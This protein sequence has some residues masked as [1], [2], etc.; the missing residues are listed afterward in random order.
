MVKGHFAILPSL[1]ISIAISVICNLLDL[2]RALILGA[3]NLVSKARVFSPH[4]LI[5][6]N[7]DIASCLIFDRCC[8]DHVE[9]K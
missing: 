2:P 1:R 4:I 5:L 9:I 3:V 6:G 7:D 8:P